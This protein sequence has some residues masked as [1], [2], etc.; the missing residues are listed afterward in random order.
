MALHSTVFEITSLE[1]VNNFLLKPLFPFISSHSLVFLRIQNP[2]D[3]FSRNCFVVIAHFHFSILLQ[4]LA[5]KALLLVT[6][7][8]SNVQHFHRLVFP[9]FIRD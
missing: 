1:H 8:G 3:L 9:I 7:N 2:N 6:A 5:S 4:L